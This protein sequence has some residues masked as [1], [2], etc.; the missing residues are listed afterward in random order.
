MGIVE[1]I[2]NNY[3]DNIP[4]WRRNYGYDGD[5]TENYA[6][7]YKLQIR[8]PNKVIFISDS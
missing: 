4:D 6:H 1:L 7:E 3:G 8:E 5:F 2:I